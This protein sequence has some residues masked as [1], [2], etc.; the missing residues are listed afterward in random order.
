MNHIDKI[1]ALPEMGLMAP[2]DRGMPCIDFPRDQLFI[3]L[4]H[5]TTDRQDVYLASLFVSSPDLYLALYELVAV[6]FAVHE[7]ELRCEREGVSESERMKEAA[8][9]GQRSLV[10]WT[11]AR[12]VLGQV[13]FPE[14][15]RK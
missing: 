3:S 4:P 6:R 5:D 9:L 13:W 11:Q 10:A 1:K 2:R 12:K 7:F 8:D 15:D 14:E